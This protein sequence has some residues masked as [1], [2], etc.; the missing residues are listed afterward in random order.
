MKLI[1]RAFIIC[2]PIWILLVL[3]NYIIP[4]SGINQVLGFINFPGVLLKIIFSPS[5][6]TMHNTDSIIYLLINF[7]FYFLLVYLILFILSRIRV[8]K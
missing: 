8:E 5:W 6:A 3:Q 2:I 7:L 1:K 4:T